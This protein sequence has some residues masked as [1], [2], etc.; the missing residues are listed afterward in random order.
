MRMPGQLSINDLKWREKNDALEEGHRVFLALLD[1]IGRGVDDLEQI[2]QHEMLTAELEGV[3]NRFTREFFQYWSQDQN[4]RVQFTL[5][6]GLPGDPAPFNEGW[7]IRTRIQD[8]RHGHSTSFD[9]RSAGFV[10]FFSF[11]VWF[12]Q[13]RQQYGEH[14]IVLLDDPGLSLHARAQADLLR[15][16]EERLAP[17]YQ[18]M[19]TTHSPFMIDAANLSR[20]RTVEKVATDTMTGQPQPTGAG[21]G[22]KVGDEV[23]SSD[24]DTLFPLQAALAYRISQPLFVGDYS[25]LVEGPSEILYFQWFKRKL[26]SLGRTSL[27]DRWVIT[28]SGGIDKI[29]AFLS[30]FTLNQLGVAVVTGALS[31]GKSS[32]LDPRGSGLLRQGQV[33]TMDAYAAKGEAGIEGII[34]RRAYIDLVQQAFSLSPEQM[35]PLGKPGKEAVP[36]VKEIEQFFTTLPQPIAKFD[37]YRPAEFLIQQSLQFDLPGLGQALDGFESLFR[38]LNAMLN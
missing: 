28:P 25:L 3:S 37:Q 20:A 33:L 35:K 32:G 19:L 11:L 7:V 14:L 4:L 30:L 18:V 5:Q 10:W 16:I 8:P 9:E 27:D 21:L 2:E 29:A 34:G 13:I 26:A 31:S 17:S 38:D 6:R 22:T 12:S 24:H 23:L 36:L 1:L 15:Y